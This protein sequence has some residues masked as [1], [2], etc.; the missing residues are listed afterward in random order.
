MLCSQCSTHILYAEGGDADEIAIADLTKQA[1]DASNEMA[2][3]LRARRDQLKAEVQAERAVERAFK[4]AQAELLKTIESAVESLGAQA[5]LNARDEQLL[6]LLLAGGLDDAVDKF[7]THQ[8]TIRD[9]VNKT[10]QASDLELS[11]ID[12]QIDMLS[13][14]NVSDVFENIILNSVKQSVRDSLTDLVVYLLHV[15][16]VF[17]CCSSQCSKAH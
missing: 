2:T 13:T 7:I 17:A 15:A 16:C 10:L 6:E 14:Q 11:V 12:A 3:L 9:A 8:Q 5:V 4:K 1:K